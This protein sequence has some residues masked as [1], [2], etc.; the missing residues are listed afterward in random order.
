MGK[1][2]IQGFESHVKHHVNDLKETL[3][4]YRHRSE[5]AENQKQDLI[6]QL[7]ELYCKLSSPLM[8]HV[9]CAKKTVGW[10]GSSLHSLWT[11]VKTSSSRGS[12]A[13]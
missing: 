6:T 5:M 2:W 7:V 13:C 9:L 12:L 11:Q 8:G 1:E 10:E 4:S 3:R